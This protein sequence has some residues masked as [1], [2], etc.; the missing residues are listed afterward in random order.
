MFPH[1][2]V[3]IVDDDEDI[4]FMS[5]LALEDSGYTVKEASDGQEAVRQIHTSVVPL[6]IITDH[7]MPTLDGPGLLTVLAA[8]PDLLGRHE[9]IYCTADSESLSPQV[10]ALLRYLHAP[11]LSKPFDIDELSHLV[12][13]TMAQMEYRQLT[14]ALVQAI[15]APGKTAGNEHA[16]STPCPI[17]DQHDEHIET[18]TENI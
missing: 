14:A 9:V 3:L 10:Q 8:D 13:H 18:T 11:V 2:H 7:S 15:T 4:R 16:T 5:R 12:Q 17:P 6:V 1:P